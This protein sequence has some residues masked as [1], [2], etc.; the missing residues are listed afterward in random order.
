MLVNRGRIMDG[1]DSEFYIDT[2]PSMSDAED[3]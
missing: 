3:A 2:R 1:L